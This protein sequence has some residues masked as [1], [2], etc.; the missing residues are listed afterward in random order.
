[1]SLRV[2]ILVLQDQVEQKGQ[3]AVGSLTAVSATRQLQTFD[4]MFESVV[5]KSRVLARNLFSNG[6]KHVF[7][8]KYKAYHTIIVWYNL[9]VL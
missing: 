1:M 3:A 9:F 7:V 6:A 4:L 2:M 8:V 5:I